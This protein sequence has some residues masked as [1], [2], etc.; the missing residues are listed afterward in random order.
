[1]CQ[2]HLSGGTALENNMTR[3]TI[4]LYW[5]PLS[6]HAHRAQLML[7]LLGQTPE[8]VEVDLMAG[9][10]KSAEFL[11]RNPLGQVPVIEDGDNVV[12]DSVAI[13]VYLAGKYDRDGHWL[14]VGPLEASRVQRWL[15]IAAGQLVAGPAAARL[16]RLFGIPADEARTR[17]IAADLFGF[18]ESELAAQPFLAGTQATIADVA[19]YSYTAHAPEGGIALEPYASIRAWLSRIEAMDGFVPMVR[20]QGAVA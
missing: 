18:M 2:R 4:R 8:L 7:S 11:K 17:T 15:S 9:Q 12:A 1:V 3:S 6:G 19:L 14:P 16:A 13:L 20:S 10:H 5:H